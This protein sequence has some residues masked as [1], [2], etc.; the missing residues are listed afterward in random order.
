MSLSDELYNSS[1]VGICV[2]ICLDDYQYLITKVGMISEREFTW[3]CLQI[4]FYLLKMY[5]I[6]FG[7]GWSTKNGGINEHYI[8]DLPGP[9]IYIYCLLCLLWVCWQKYMN[10]TENFTCVGNNR[11]AI[12]EKG[13]EKKVGIKKTSNIHRVY[14]QQTGKVLRFSPNTQKL[15]NPHTHLRLKVLLFQCLENLAV[16]S[17]VFQGWG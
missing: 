11:D 13:V 2:I 1:N 8:N 7:K 9:T 5:S 17:T 6:S 12:W 10:F 15:W 3:S 4:F 14:Q 16:S